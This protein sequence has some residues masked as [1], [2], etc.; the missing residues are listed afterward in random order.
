MLN[1]NGFAGAFRNF[2]FEI[3]YGL[4][5]RQNWLLNSLGN[6]HDCYWTSDMAIPAVLLYH[7]AFISV[8]LSLSDLHVAAGRSGING[9]AEIAENSLRR[10]AN[11]ESA[12]VTMSHVEKCLPLL[13]ADSWRVQASEVPLK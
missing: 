2:A 6:W 1:P 3:G 11:S 7:L 4:Q 5:D 8:N 12:D 13:M 10:W 9:E